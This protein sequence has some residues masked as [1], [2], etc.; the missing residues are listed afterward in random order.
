MVIIKAISLDNESYDM[1]K[2][3]LKIDSHFNLSEFV[4]NSIK[5]EYEKTNPANLV[6]QLEELKKQEL[7]VKLKKEEINK[8]VVEI[9]EKEEKELIQHFKTEEELQKIKDEKIINFIS[10]CRDYFG[11]GPEI[12]EEYIEEWLKTDMQLKEFLASKNLI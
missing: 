5:K 7:I 3:M 10:S 1:L 12:S 4:R 2:E 11:I 6:K 9:K 8:N